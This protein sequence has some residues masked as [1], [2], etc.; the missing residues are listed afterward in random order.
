MPICPRR[1]A[2]PVLQDRD[3]GVFWSSGIPADAEG[4]RNRRF[5]KVSHLLPRR[6]LEGRAACFIPTKRAL[7]GQT[8]GS[9][10]TGGGM[11]GRNSPLRPG[12]AAPVNDDLQRNPPVR[13]D[14]LFVRCDQNSSKKMFIPSLILS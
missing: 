14:I 10:L 5:S 9:P 7:P 13:C 3:C 12:E 2:P 6:F 4:T 8:K 11:H 1:F